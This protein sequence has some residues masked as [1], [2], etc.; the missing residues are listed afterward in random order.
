MARGW[1]LVLCV[2]LAA[3]ASG[4]GGA[5]GDGGGADAP[6][7]SDILALG[8]HG[9]SGRASAEAMGGGTHV[10]V[11]LTGGSAGGVHPWHVHEGVCESNGPIVGAAAA[12][13]PLQP[14]ASG[15]ANAEAHLEVALE[16]GGSYYV[17][18]HQSASDLGTVVGCGQLRP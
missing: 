17:N 8:G 3:C 4:R 18:I 5:G 7:T 13:P 16:P 6:W 12:Y 14:D 1:L 2:G 10:T 9:H 11:F 15:N